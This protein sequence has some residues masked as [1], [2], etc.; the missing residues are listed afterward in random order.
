[1]STITE[2]EK[3]ALLTM[4]RQYAKLA[5]AEPAIYADDYDVASLVAFEVL[6]VSYGEK[7]AERIVDD[8]YNQVKRRRKTS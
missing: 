7:E 4:V 5:L 1:M 3:N 8:I 6:R 2:N